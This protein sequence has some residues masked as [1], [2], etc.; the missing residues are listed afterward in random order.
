MRTGEKLSQ[1]DSFGEEHLYFHV[2]AL[3]EFDARR[4]AVT[5]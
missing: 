4:K 5:L 2:M 3:S 1:H